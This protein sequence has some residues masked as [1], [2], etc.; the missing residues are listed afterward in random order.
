MAS[1][2]LG[3]LVARRELLIARAAHERDELAQLLGEVG[4]HAQRADARISQAQRLLTHPFMIAG[5][6]GAIVVVGPRRLFTSAKRSGVFWLLL[7]NGLPI[8]RKVLARWIG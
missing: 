1:A 8:A 4:H 5:V 3:E 7:R 6:V 2:R